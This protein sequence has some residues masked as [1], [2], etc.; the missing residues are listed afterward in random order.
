MRREREKGVAIIFL[1]VVLMLLFAFTAVAV[2]IGVAYSEQRRIHNVT[3]SAALAGAWAALT[4]SSTGKIQ[5][6]AQ[7]VALAPEN[8]L[9]L[10]EL[11]LAGATAIHAGY[12][13]VKNGK[14]D[15][16]ADQVAPGTSSYNA[17]KVE[18]QRTV[19]RYFAGILDWPPLRPRVSSVAL[20]ATAGSANCIIPFGIGEALLATVAGNELVISNATTGGPGGKKG[21]PQQSSGNWGKLNIGG[22]DVGTP[23][24][25]TEAMMQTAGCFTAEIQKP[26]ENNTNPNGIAGAFI[27]RMNSTSPGPKVVMAVVDE[28][29]S[30]GQGNEACGKPGNDCPVVLGFVTAEITHVEV[31]STAQYTI[32][33]SIQPNITGGWSGAAATSNYSGKVPVIIN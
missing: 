1:C 26:I 15:F 12:A 29:P 18:A 25:F 10:S 11:T 28:F 31:H 21:P 7:A 27:D 13:E 19:P 17:V 2:D 3:D 14:W 24:A 9:T 22:F 32:T 6:V 20:I 5:E 8:G 16:A 30:G 4:N 33:F 23:K